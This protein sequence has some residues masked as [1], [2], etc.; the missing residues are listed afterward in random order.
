VSY[1]T[2]ASLDFTIWKLKTAWHLPGR[3]HLRCEAQTGNNK[4]KIVRE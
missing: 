2:K 4:I 1:R 3:F